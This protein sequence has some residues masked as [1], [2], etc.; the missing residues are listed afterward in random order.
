M[1]FGGSVGQS[2][3]QPE[4][5]ATGSLD[6]LPDSVKEIHLPLGCLLSDSLSRP[7]VPLYL[8]AR[9][10][11]SIGPTARLSGLITI[12]G[13]D[14]IV[15]ENGARVEGCVIVALRGVVVQGAQLSSVQILSSCIDFAG[16]STASYPTIA[17]SIPLD[18]AANLDQSLTVQS[19]A[20]LEGFVGLISQRG[21]DVLTLQKGSS[22]AGS[23]FSTAR[24][25][26][27][28]SVVGSAFAYDL[29]FYDAPAIYL[30]W[31]RMGG[32]DRDALPGG[33]LIPPIFSGGKEYDVLTWN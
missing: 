15:I 6:H 1:I 19:G 21:D 4:Y 14:S 16:G 23:V 24:L 2:T 18:T 10:R 13:P 28:G 7:I 22:I 5:G 3:T 17:L 33:F 29:Y 12:A 8:L 20:N 31:M 30:G 9:G 25:T 26:L 27:D 32:I 11:I